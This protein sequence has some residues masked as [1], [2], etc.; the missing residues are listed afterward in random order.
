MAW[1]GFDAGGNHNKSGRY[2][3]HYFIGLYLAC[4]LTFAPHK[5][6]SH[7]LAGF[8]I[9]IKDLIFR[10]ESLYLSFDIASR[11]RKSTAIIR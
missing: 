2:D 3:R 5:I 6:I 8:V 11:L 9:A 4:G 10:K 7:Y 1:V